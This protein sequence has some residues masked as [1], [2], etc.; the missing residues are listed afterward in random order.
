MIYVMFKII[1]RE[2]M[3]KLVGLDNVGNTCYMN[4]CLQILIRC[5]KLTNIFIK[6]DF[7]NSNLNIYKRFLQQ[8]LEKGRSLDRSKI[9]IPEEIKIIVDQYNK[10]FQNNRQHDC[11][12]FLI[13]FLNLV[14]DGFLDEFH[15]LKIGKYDPNINGVILKDVIKH[16]FDFTII[17]EVEC[18]R[19]LFSS[20]TKEKHRYLILPVFQ[21]LEDS[22]NS[23]FKEERLDNDNQW[24]CEKCKTYVE[25][26]KRMTIDHLPKYV[27]I[28]LKRFGHLNDSV[29][30]T[31]KIDIPI[32]MEINEKSYQLYGSI[33]HIGNIKG[34]HYISYINHNDNWYLLN[35]SHVSIMNENNIKNEIDKSYIFFYERC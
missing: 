34:G 9:I 26:T 32:K 33:K 7:R 16:L 2:K 13:T 4:S 19:C 10:R 24:F 12:E 17:S 35:D 29:K 20:K 23:F 28:H 3:E 27:I 14:E 30:I 18:H 8:Y 11:H 31:S 15:K 6:N 1:Y 5:Q 22:F 21:T 25:S